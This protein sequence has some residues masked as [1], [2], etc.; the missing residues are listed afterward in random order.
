MSEKQK[1]LNFIT[2]LDDNLSVNDILYEIMLYF[3]IQQG[4]SDIENGRTIT[5]EEMKELILKCWFGQ[6]KLKKM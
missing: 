6:N 2:S 4:L 5:N 3:K 1:L